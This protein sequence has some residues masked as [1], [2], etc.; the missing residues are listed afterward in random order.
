M[1]WMQ[2]SWD[3]N[4]KI[5]VTNVDGDL[6]F[7]YGLSTSRR[8]KGAEVKWRGFTV[9]FTGSEEDKSRLLGKGKNELIVENTYFSYCYITYLLQ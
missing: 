7:S 5:N 4:D 9:D 1:N 3:E 6:S 8:K 2:F